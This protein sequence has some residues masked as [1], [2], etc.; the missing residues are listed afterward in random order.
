MDAISDQKRCVLYDQLKII[1]IILVVLGHC[2]IMF[3]PDGAIPVLRKS[4]IL[5]YSAS[6]LYRFHIPCFFM[7]SGAVFAFNLK[8]GKYGVFREFVGKKAVRLLIPYGIFGLFIVLPVLIFCGLIDPS[9]WYSFFWNLISGREVRHLWY[10]YSLFFVFLLFRAFWRYIDESDPKKVLAVS[11]VLSFVSRSMPFEFLSYFQIG[12]IFYYQ[13]FFIWGIF[14]DRYFGRLILYF[15]EHRYFLFLS[16][17]LLLMSCFVDLYTLSGYVYAA[18]G[19]ILSVSLALFLCGH[20]K[21]A[22]SKGRNI[23]AGDS[24]GIYLFH[25]MIIYLI[26]FGFS[27]REVSVILLL[28][29][30]LIVSFFGSLIL[31]ELCRRA[32]LGFMIGEGRKKTLGSD[33][34]AAAGKK[35]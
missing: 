28:L 35:R 29:L 20:E 16:G 5:T 31:T 9:R 33:F 14:F 8:K 11:F 10:L 12:N 22:D 4:V 17:L 32:H 25:P 30:S 18:A 23:L 6:I 3:S 19:V 26:F 7:V 13:F 15:K 2:F 1:T 24:Y 27:G 34:G 21:W